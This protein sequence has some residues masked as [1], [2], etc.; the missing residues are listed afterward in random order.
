MFKKVAMAMGLSAFSFFGVATAAMAYTCPD[1]YTP[2]TVIL[3][4]S[5]GTPSRPIY[6]CCTG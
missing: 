1:G 6:G 3:V 5:D 2:C 4:N